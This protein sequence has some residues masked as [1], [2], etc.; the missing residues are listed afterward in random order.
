MVSS[1]EELAPGSPEPHANTFQLIWFLSVTCVWV[2]LSGVQTVRHSLPETAFASVP[3][4]R[5]PSPLP[6]SR[7]HLS[8]LSGAAQDIR[9]ALKRDGIRGV[10][11]AEIDHVD[12]FGPAESD[13]VDSRNFVYCPGG[14]YDRSPCGTG[15]SAKLAC[16]AAD[17]KLQPGEPWVQESI[18]GSRFVGTYQPRSPGT[19]IPTITGTA[20]VYGECR[21]IVQ[22]GDPFPHG[23]E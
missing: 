16:L 17:E 9:D 23:I 21:F 11:G 4:T 18:I 13:D 19:I 20:Y 10:G 2:L 1:A 8:E 5:T 6:L 15:T 3:T 12:F 14:A 22:D 7:S